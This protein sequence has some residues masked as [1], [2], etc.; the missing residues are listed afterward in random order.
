MSDLFD[1]LGVEAP[2]RTSLAVP[3]KDL[4]DKLGVKAP[5]VQ[6]GSQDALASGMLFNFGDEAGAAVR[7]TV[8]PAIKAGMKFVKGLD[9]KLGTDVGGGAEDFDKSTMGQSSDAPDWS[10]RYTDELEKSRAKNAI[11]E[12]QHPA[13]ATASNVLGNVAGTAGMVA[14]LPPAVGTALFTRGASGVGNVLKGAAVGGTLGGVAGYGAGE[15]DNR[16]TNALMGG[17]F[18][19]AVGGAIPPAAAI[20]RSVMESAPGRYV[21]EKIVSPALRGVSSVFGGNAPKSLSAAAADGGIPPSLLETLA[22]KTGNVAN[23]AMVDRLATAVQRSGRSPQSLQR[24]I[25][26]LGPEAVLADLDPQLLS[27][28]RGVKVLPGAT[29][30]HAENVLESRE[31]MEPG[32]LRRSFEGDEPP[33]SNYQLR[34]EGQAFEKNIQAVGNRAYDAMDQAGL[35]QTP[36]L[37]AIYENPHV[38]DAIERT[39]AADKSTRIGTDIAPASPIEIM[40][41]VKQAIWDLGF[42]KDTARPGPNASFYRNLGTKYMDLLKQANPKLAE[43]DA[44]FSQANSLPE[45]YDKGRNALLGGTGDNATASS[46]AGLADVLPGADIQQQLS[47]RAGMT[48]TVRDMTSGR[49]ALS[50]TRALARDLPAEGIEAKV[51]ALYEADHAAD[52]QRAG[53]SIRTFAKTSNKILRGSE[54]AEKAAD[55]MDVGAGVKVTPGGVTP[56]IY[57]SLN[58]IRNWVVNPNEAVRDEMGRALINMNLEENRRLLQAINQA[59]RGRAEPNALR[60]LAS[61]SAGGQASR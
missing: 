4:F 50:Q 46:A 47:A 59:L 22:D 23:S 36:E 39:L 43:A 58:A 42:D 49:N 20:G 57:E 9:Q 38:N 37:M 55:A 5:T 45:F 6:E 52:I 16:L 41:K 35:K 3:K 21:S 51:N 13:M 17:G 30:T 31:K 40:H 12:A 26:Q 34:G 28:A 29:R 44:A 15:G 11:F 54:T 1:K 27:V 14:A 7:A 24:M 32:I 18:G 10:A 19:A 56:R 48:N 33:P 60:A 25:D 61:S 2:P 53:N 8:G